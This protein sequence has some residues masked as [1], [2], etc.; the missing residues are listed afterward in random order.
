M[1]SAVGGL[2]CSSFDAITGNTGLHPSLI[3]WQQLSV[4]INQNHPCRC[5]WLPVVTQ[6]DRGMFRRSS[7][8]IQQGRRKILFAEGVSIVSP[9]PAEYERKST[10]DSGDPDDSRLFPMKRARVIDRAQIKDAFF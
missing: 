2:G 10:A 1:P 4:A 8:G 7:G 3:G 5:Q 9:M 6:I